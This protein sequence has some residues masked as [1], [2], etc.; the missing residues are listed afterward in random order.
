[1]ESYSPMFES[2]SKQIFTCIDS[3]IVGG[4]DISDFLDGLRNDGFIY[5]IER[6]DVIIKRGA[7]RHTETCNES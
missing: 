5:L 7:T 4:A 6:S 2:L 3:E 1:M